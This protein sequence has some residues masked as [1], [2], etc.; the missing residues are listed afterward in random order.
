VIESHLDATRLAGSD[1]C[2]RVLLVGELN[3]Y[4]VDPRYALYYLPA[5]SA[6]GRLQRDVLGVR[7]RHTY[8]PLWRANLCT[9]RWDLD[10]AIARASVLS[11]RSA[12]ERPWRAIVALGVS[13]ARAFCEAA[14][15]RR[16]DLVDGPVEMPSGILLV[17]LPHPSG[18]NFSWNG[19]SG[20]E[21]VRRVRALL[22][23]VEPE[24]PWGELD[25]ASGQN[26]GA[27]GSAS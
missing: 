18:R 9:R 12:G 1:A 15:L 20:L 10:E 13:V 5:N 21:T 22:R 7:A 11:G 3:P 6:G 14:R 8:L 19:A 4:G 2:R 16:M 17:S 26:A 23:S 24:V 27:G 25:A